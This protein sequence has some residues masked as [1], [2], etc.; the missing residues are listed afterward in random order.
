MFKLA[1]AR[2]MGAS[3]PPDPGAHRHPANA[4]RKAE[5]PALTSSL[6]MAACD[7]TGRLTLLSPTLRDLLG[8]SFGSNVADEPAVGRHLYRNDGVTSLQPEHLPLARARRGEV[9]TDVVICHRSEEEIPT[10]LRCNAAPVTAEDDSVS[11]AVVFV[12]DVTASQVGQRNRQRMHDHLVGTLNHAIR[13]PLTVLVGHAERLHDMRGDLPVNALP[14][15]KQ[16]TQAADEL[17]ELADLVS[18][19][20]DLE[21]PGRLT[22]APDGPATSARED[23]S[24]VAEQLART[25][26][27]SVPEIPAHRVAGLDTTTVSEAIA[28]LAAEPSAPRP[29]R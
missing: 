1:I 11:G 14:S 9:V 2:T 15:L 5:T 8:Q 17:S 19:L 21:S 27:S 13:T 6:G 18:C 10:Y 29:R 7:A 24:P 25:R 22:E 16:V 28:A 23:P 4:G 3:A 12:E 26:L 20:A